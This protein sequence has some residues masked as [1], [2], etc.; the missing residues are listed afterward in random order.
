[1]THTHAKSQGQRSLD[2]KVTVET[3]DSQMNGWMFFALPRVLTQSVFMAY[4]LTNLSLCVGRCS[5]RLYC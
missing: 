5:S 1:M 2:S 4:L 3:T